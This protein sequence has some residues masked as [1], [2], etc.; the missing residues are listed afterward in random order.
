VRILEAT[1]VKFDWETFQVGA[2]AF[3]K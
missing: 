1:G 2:D 3:E